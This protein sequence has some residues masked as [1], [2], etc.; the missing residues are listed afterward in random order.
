MARNTG[1]KHRICRRAGEALCGQ[2]NCPALRRPY[3]PGMHGAQGRRRRQS[4]YGQQLLEK[5]KLRHIYGVLERQ[6]RRYFKEAVRERGRPGERL[7]QQLETRLDNLVYR[8]GLAR[9]RPQAR[10]LVVHG[11]VLLNGRRVTIPS[12]QVKPGDEISIRPKSRGLAIIQEAL[13]LGAVPP[14][15]LELDAERFSGRL[16]RLPQREEIPVQVDESLIV[17]LY[18]R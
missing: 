12:C 17:A 13:S 7:L 5:Q 11:H 3:P 2:P 16:L 9:T 8:L 6:L 15:Y 10:Q 4:V 14:P 1:P 18:A